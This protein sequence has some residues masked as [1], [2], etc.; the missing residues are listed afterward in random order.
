MLEPLKPPHLRH[1]KDYEILER[2]WTPPGE[3][4]VLRISPP[5]LERQRAWRGERVEELVARARDR[6]LCGFT[7][8][9]ATARPRGGGS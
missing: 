1:R 4:V 9:R 7:S 3:S 8:T 6:G 2:R 5:A